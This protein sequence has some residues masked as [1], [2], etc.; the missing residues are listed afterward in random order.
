M[1]KRQKE[2]WRANDEKSGKQ[3]E[4]AKYINKYEKKTFFNL[5]V[6]DFD[7]EDI[8]IFPISLL[9]KKHAISF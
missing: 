9:S 7:V 3:A 6:F 5:W 4:K 8:L 2:I 1:Y